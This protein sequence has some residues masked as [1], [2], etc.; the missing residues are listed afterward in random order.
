MGS[1]KMEVCRLKLGLQDLWEAILTCGNVKSSDLL[2]TFCVDVP[3]QMIVSE[4]EGMEII[5]NELAM[6][7]EWDWNHC[8]CL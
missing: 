7:Q 8:W 2:M 3:E 5:L 4:R 1:V 6:K